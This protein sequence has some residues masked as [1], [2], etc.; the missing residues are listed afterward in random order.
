ML[1]APKQLSLQSC[2]CGEVFFG[3]SSHGKARW[4]DLKVTRWK[5]GCSRAIRG[6]KSIEHRLV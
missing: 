6:R 4:R 5:G 3:E 1:M 2:T